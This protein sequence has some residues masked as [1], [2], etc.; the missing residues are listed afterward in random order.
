[1]TALLPANKVISQTTVTM[2]AAGTYH[3]LF[4][5]SDSS[6]W[7]MGYNGDAELGNG[8]TNNLLSPIMLVSTNVIAASGGYAHS[9]FRI[10]TSASIPRNKAV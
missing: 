5:K 9:L 3:T 8:T 6:L 10:R 1:M 2:V 4:I 7:G